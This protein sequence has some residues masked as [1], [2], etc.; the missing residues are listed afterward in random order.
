MKYLLHSNHH[1]NDGFLIPE[2]QGSKS[3]MIYIY[4]LGMPCS[5]E[6]YIEA[7]YS[8]TTQQCLENIESRA[9]LF[10]PVLQA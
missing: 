5:N 2:L 9:F 7:S 8:N 6:T 1:F 4:G 3:L 10:G